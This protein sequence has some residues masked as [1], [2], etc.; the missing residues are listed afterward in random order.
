MPGAKMV[1]PVILFTALS[2]WAGGENA[3]WTAGQ[4]K[5]LA[6][7]TAALPPE[8]RADI[9]LRLA[10][11]KTAAEVIAAG[12]VGLCDVI[13]ITGRE[14]ARSE[15]LFSVGSAE[16][17]GTAPARQSTGSLS[18]RPNAG[19]IGQVLD[20]VEI[21]GSGTHFVDGVSRLEFGNSAVTALNLV[22]S[23]AT[24][25]TATVAVADPVGRWKRE[26]LEDA[27][28]TAARAQLPYRQR[29]EPTT[30]TRAS[31]AF[32]PNDLEALTLRSRVVDAMLPLDARRGRA[33][34]EELQIPEIP[35]LRCQDISTPQVRPYYDTAA[36]L[37]ARS[38]TPEERRR[39]E[40][41]L[42]LERLILLMRSP[43]QV[44]PVATLIFGVSMSPERR[45][46]VVAAF[47]GALAR[48]NGSPRLFGDAP[49]LLYS[50]STKPVELPPD[51]AATAP[52][53]VPA[54][55]AYIVRSERGPRCSE[56]IER[57]QL[58]DSVL[59]FNAV[60]SRLDPTGAVYKPISAEESKAS[61]DAG[62]YQPH[63]W[64]QSKRSK[65]VLQ[66]MK[67]LNHGNR[68][69][70]DRQR[71]WTLD[72]RRSTEWESRFIDTLKLIEGWRPDEEESSD[73]W[74]GMVA[75][76]YCILAKLAPPGGLRD[77]AMERC[78]AFLQQHYA[79]VE[80][81]NL[82]FTVWT[83]LLFSKDLWILEH[84]ARSS[85]PVMALYAEVVTLAPE[86]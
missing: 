41:V 49:L 73:D 13:V 84:L 18:I 59:H 78:V 29:G 40:D 14:S 48:V 72:E 43:P 35:L 37:F 17:T 55:R 74:F 60:V 82:W 21:V 8:F 79:D 39:D 62:T 45:Q 11:S 50:L 57:D 12:A 20:K 4:I 71:F 27:F 46:R 19:R 70:P 32:W 6:N 51:L 56:Y 24:H 80:N 7:R 75:R 58:P 52:T 67:W 77:G 33:L 22:V 26:L 64:W 5:E 28:H 65:D 61:S 47:S 81:H 85:N 15:A 9:L 38:F 36:K 1:A 31:R 16:P 23:D 54:L 10:G 68:D 66:A 86:I 83:D 44:N 53:L 30:D 3:H 69:L 63:M 34:F 76:T 2:A 42:F 25:L